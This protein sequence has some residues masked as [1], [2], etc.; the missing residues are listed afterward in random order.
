MYYKLRL[1]FLTWSI[2]EQFMDAKRENA[3]SATGTKA[4]LETII[5]LQSSMIESCR[6]TS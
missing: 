3:D 5:F 2:R 4:V 6:V 1:T